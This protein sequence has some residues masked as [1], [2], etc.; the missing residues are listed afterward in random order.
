M[1]GLWFSVCGFGARRGLVA[2]GSL[3]PLGAKK[4]CSVRHTKGGFVCP[5]F[6]WADN[7]WLWKRLSHSASCGGVWFRAGGVVCF[8]RRIIC[9]SVS[10][11]LAKQLFRS[12]D[13]KP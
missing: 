1:L 11:A 9:L 13:P 12:P 7:A 2:G 3:A 5:N 10:G 4:Y 8:D 6:L